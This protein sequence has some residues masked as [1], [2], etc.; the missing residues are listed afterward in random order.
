MPTSL[1][2]KN[3]TATVAVTVVMINPS[4]V[5]FLAAVASTV[6]PS[7]AGLFFDHRSISSFI[8][9]IFSKA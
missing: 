3:I 6:D 5:G 8:I 2:P 9:T 1:R 7:S 4:P